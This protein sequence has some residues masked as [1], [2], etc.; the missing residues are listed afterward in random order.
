VRY[1]LSES[2][3]AIL[4]ALGAD[5]GGVSFLE[6]R[7]AP[8]GA[9]AAGCQWKITASAVEN[10]D[11]SVL[12]SVGPG[13][14]AWGAGVNYSNPGEAGLGPLQPGSSARVV[15]VTAAPPLPLV[16]EPRWPTG[17]A[18]ECGCEGCH[19]LTKK[20]DA[21]GTGGDSG[22]LLLVAPSWSAPTGTTDVREIGAV[23]VSAAGGVSIYQLQRDTIVARAIVGR[24]DGG[25]DEP[26][27][28]P[29]C[30]HPLNAQD[31]SHP[32]DVGNTA[33][34]GGHPLD[35]PGEGGY[36]PECADNKNAAT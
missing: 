3:A 13:L 1:L 24:K 16:N 2:S 17:N 10:G 34:G 15:W 22:A 4:R 25:G 28:T 7:I 23:A 20:G 21:A 30:G 12:V 11:G 14:V 19:C 26:D 9:L 36:T 5:H 29:P 18:P 8:P 33:G 32:F 35:S 31:D 6:R 27:E